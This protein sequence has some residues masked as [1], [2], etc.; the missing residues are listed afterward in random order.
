M[1][2]KKVIII[3]AVIIVVPFIIY[4]MLI[5]LNV[6]Q[7]NNSNPINGAMNAMSVSDKKFVQSSVTLY[8]AKIT[9]ENKNKSEP[10]ITAGSI[11]KGS[12]YAMVGSKKYIIDKQSL[13]ISLP[14]GNWYIDK[15]GLVTVK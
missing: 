8:I 2:F 10:V 12:A 3:I 7:L 15:T 4:L 1:N 13:G 5:M 6:I 9:A 14:K 11:N